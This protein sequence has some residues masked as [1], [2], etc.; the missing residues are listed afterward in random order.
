[1]TTQTRPTT[2]TPPRT[3]M[4]LAPVERLIVSMI[5]HVAAGKGFTALADLA[6]RQGGLAADA[7]ATV[8]RHAHDMARRLDDPE[9]PDINVHAIPCRRLSDDELTVLRLLAA[10]QVDDAVSASA[11]AHC[12]VGAPS[13]GPI[14]AATRDLAK[15]LAA[16]GHGFR[17]DA[18]AP[19]IAWRPAAE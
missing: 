7:S 14:L 15:T 13:V 5:R 19:R 2:P 12:L 1:M 9:G 17:V 10:S 11:F 16:I 4:H 3:L 6:E 18:S 8:A